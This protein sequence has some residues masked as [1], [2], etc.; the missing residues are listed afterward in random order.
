MLLISAVFS[1][2]CFLLRFSNVLS[3]FPQFFWPNLLCIVDLAFSFLDALLSS[4]SEEVPESVTSQSIQISSASLYFWSRISIIN[5]SDFFPSYSLRI[6]LT[7]SLG[8]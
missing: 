2:F 7:F 5:I 6:K 8:A 4:A 3:G 1:P